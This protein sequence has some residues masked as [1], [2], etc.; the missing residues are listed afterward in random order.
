M[1]NPSQGLTAEEDLMLIDE[2]NNPIGSVKRKEMR[3][4]KLWHR[5]SY[6]FV[7]ND[8]NEVL[9]QKRTMIKD[10]CPGYFDLASG[11]CQ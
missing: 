11:G 8:K 2:F 6:V 4:K 1:V 5:A 3:A 10:Y 7:I 9:V